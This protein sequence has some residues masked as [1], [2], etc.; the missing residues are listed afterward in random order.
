[1]S[2]VDLPGIMDS[3]MNTH[4]IMRGSRANGPGVRY[5]IWFQGCSIRCPGCFN[6][7]THSHEPRL[8][9]QVEALVADIA[10]L[11]G[12]I[13][14][15]T[16]SGGE[17]LE[18]MDGLL[19]LLRGIREQTSLTVIL[20]TG[21]TYEEIVRMPDADE[22]LRLV[23]VLIA[24]RYDHTR[25]TAR[26]LM[27]SSNKTVHFLTDSYSQADLDVVPQLEIVIL[28][29]GTVIESGIDPKPGGCF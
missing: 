10:S 9:M 13:E 4:A 6:P 24:G 1:M 22:L 17:P 15:V 19:A 28:P 5:V 25:R 16:I 23:D 27:G 11:S 3:S 26:G 7:G 2:A 14:G 29:D 20:F 18:Q 8:T 12:E 21:Y